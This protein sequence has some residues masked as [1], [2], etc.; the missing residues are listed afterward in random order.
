[1]TVQIL[2]N[3]L[4]YIDR[5]VR[6]GFSPDQAR[7]SAEALESAL[8]ETVATKSDIAEVKHEI[9]SARTDLEHKITDAQARLELKIEQAKTETLRWFFAVALGLVGAIFAIVKFVH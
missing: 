6:G 8:T 1:M 4:A 9:N 5:L 7:A 3:Q 2:F